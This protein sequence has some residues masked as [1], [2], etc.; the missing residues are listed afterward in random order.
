MKFKVTYTIEKEYDYDLKEWLNGN[1]GLT[2]QEF[3]ECVT[4]WIGED[5]DRIHNRAAN[6][7]GDF[8]DQVTFEKYE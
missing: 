5:F 1:P 7:I 3:Q 8:T 6:V 4:N 2:E